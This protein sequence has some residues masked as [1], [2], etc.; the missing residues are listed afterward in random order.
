MST[1]ANEALGRIKVTVQGSRPAGHGQRLYRR[2]RALQLGA[3]LIAILMPVTGLF[4]IDPAAGAFVILDRQI[5]FSDFFLV[6][7][8][9]L[10]VSSLLVMTYSALGTAFCGWV[11]PQNTLSEWANRMTQKFLGK[12]AEVS[13]EGARVKVS[14]GKRKWSNWAMLGALFLGASMIAALIPLLYFYPP[15]AIWSFITLQ[16]DERLAGSLHWIYTIFVL[17]IFVNIAVIRYFF[18]RFMCVYRVWQHSF[19]TRQTLHIEYD[20]LRGEQCAKCNYCVTVC[21]VDIDPRNTSIY[22]SCINCGACI[23]A[24]DSLQTKKGESSLL[25]FQFGERGQSK[26]S[27]LRHK[28][29]SLLGRA[30]WTAPFAL[31]GAAMFVWG[32]WSYQPFHFS[33]YRADTLQGASIQDY[34][35]NVANKLYQPKT[36]EISV[37]GLPQGVYELSEQQA[38]FGTAGRVNINL[39]V[40]P[41]LSPGLYAF[42]VQVQAPN[43]WRDSYRVQHFVPRS[44]T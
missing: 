1:S 27:E 42:T 40:R 22:D 4:R 29:A 17:A 9:W 23:T 32:L 33:V 3:I 10:M 11:C 18:C 14:A 6:C 37:Q 36:L 34:R 25:R 41:D 30:T 44:E 28:L 19:K 2:R 13:L 5:W 38:A 7:G 39:H 31:I 12:R 35:I 43:G 16:Q 15:G 21:P 8:F 26:H 20:A 24:C